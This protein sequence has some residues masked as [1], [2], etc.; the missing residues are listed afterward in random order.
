MS[1]IEC[2]D[3]GSA[4]NANGKISVYVHWGTTPI[5]QMKIEL[6]QTGEVKYT[7]ERGIAEFI[8]PPGSYVV[9]VYNL[10]R[11]GPVLMYVDFPIDAK[12][13]EVQTLDVVDCLPCV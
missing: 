11:G 2:T 7:D 1:S 10:N 12:S 13:N 8:L 4:L 5:S 6:V 9:R 3:M